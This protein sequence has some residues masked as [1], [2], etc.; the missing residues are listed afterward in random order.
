[1]KVFHLA[2]RFAQLGLAV[3]LIVVEGVIFKVGVV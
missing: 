2:A 1:M 3:I